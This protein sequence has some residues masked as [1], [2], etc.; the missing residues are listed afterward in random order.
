[1]DKRKIFNDCPSVSTL[2]LG[3]VNFG[4]KLPEE[5]ALHQLDYFFENGGNFIDTA[6][7]YGRWDSSGEPLS[8]QA[9]GKWLKERK[10]RS[11]VVISTKGGHPDLSSMD[12]PRLSEKEIREDVESSLRSLGTDYIDIYFLHRDD[13]EKPVEEIL[14]ILEKLRGEGKILHYGC[15][16]WKL[17]RIKESD[18]ASMWLKAEGFVINQLMWSLADMRVNSLKDKTMI[19]MDKETYAYHKQ[20]GKYAMAY[21]S[22]AKGYFSKILHGSQVKDTDKALYDTP[23]NRL[24]LEELPEIKKRLEVASTPIMLAYIMRQPFTS[25]PI[26]S[27]SSVAQLEEGMTA[28]NLK[29]PDD[30]FE[31]LNKSRRFVYFS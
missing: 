1:M 13:Q 8:E 2:C 22:A 20:T 14:G 17:R 23:S 31:M 27:F 16:N 10:V 12:I 21:M 25:F 11:E 7:V 5:D 26:A 24:L 3:T 4:T 6:N 30:I 15:S 18:A 9:I 29:M 28:M 19:P